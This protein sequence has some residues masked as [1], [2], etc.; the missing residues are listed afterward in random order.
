MFDSVLFLLAI[1][2]RL[3]ARCS[4]FQYRL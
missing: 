1:I 3:K 4:V 2:I